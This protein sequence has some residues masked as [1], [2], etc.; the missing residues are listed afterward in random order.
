MGISLGTNQY[1]KAEV[2]LVH[3]DRS[4]DQ[5]VLK[6]FNVTSQLMGDFTDAHLTG[7]NDMVIATDTQKN[8][9]YALAKTGGVSSPEEFALRMARNFVDKYDWITGARQEVE[10][11][12]WDHNE[13]DGTPVGFSFRKSSPE[14]RTAVVVKDGE[15]ETVISGLTNLVVLNSAHSEFWGFPQVEYTA[16]VETTDRVLATA[17]T[18]RWI[19][20]ST[21]VDWDSTYDAV[22]S[23]MLKMFAETHSLSLQ[24][25]IYAMGSAVL[26]KFPEVAEVRLSCPNKHHFLVDLK[27]F[28]LEN[29][30]EVF[31][32]AD[33]PYGLIQAAI[34]RDDA[35][36]DPVAWQGVGGFI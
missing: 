29:D 15:S 36:V 6:D 35:P 18:A 7:A 21:E 16:L 3:L 19:Y 8:T 9:V 13:V 31:Y 33:R 24:Q 28:G 14:V 23:L 30:N 22:R 20:N 27:H 34:V 5:H 4:A 17:V 32:A 26:E 12:Y 1:G 11:Y 2:R 10:A 25:T